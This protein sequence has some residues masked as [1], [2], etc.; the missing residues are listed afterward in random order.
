[1]FGWFRREPRCPVNSHLRRWTEYGMRWLADQFGM[2]RLKATQV[3]LP[4]VDFCPEPYS[5]TAEGARNLCRRVSRYI[6]VDPKQLNLEFYSVRLPDAASDCPHD[7][8]S[9]TIWLD[10]SDVEDPVPVVVNMAHHAARLIL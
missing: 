10:V 9:R 7:S 4:T 2:D 3:V 6:G 5:P 8:P 1:M